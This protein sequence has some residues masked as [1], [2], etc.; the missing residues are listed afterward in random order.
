MKTPIASVIALCTALAL[1]SFAQAEDAEPDI[2]VMRG[3]RVGPGLNFAGRSAVI[4]PNGAAATAHPLATQT[5]IDILRQGGSAVDAAIAANA[6]LGLVEPVGN[7]MGG[8]L[9][10]LIWDP[11]TEQL[12]GLNA[13][14]RSPMGATLE[15]MQAIADELTE[16]EEIP[17]YGSA[18]VT[19]PGAVDGWYMMHE[20]F[21]QMDMAELFA[22]T[23]H[24]AESGAPIPELISF[25]WNISARR[26]NQ[27]YEAGILE[28]VDNANAT[29]F[30]PAPEEG[31]LFQNPDLANTLRILSEGGREAFYEG[32]IAETM[33]AYFERIGGF[34]RYDDFASHQ[35]EWVDP[36]C[37]NYRESRVCGL[38]PNTQGVATLQ[39]LQ[40]LEDFPMREYGFGSADS[41]MA[42][43]EAKRLAFEDRALGYADM[44]FFEM[45][46]EAFIDPEYGE[47]RAAEIDL[48]TANTDLRSG[49]L[50]LQMAEER[51]R[52]GD[53]TYLTVADSN[54][55]MVSL[56]QSNYR[57]MGSGPVADGLGFMFQDRGQLFSLD[58]DHPNV[59]EPGKRPFHTIIPG[60]AFHQTECKEDCSY[61]PWLS[62]GVMGG[63][64]QPQGQTQIILNLIDYDMDLQEAGDAARWRH[65]GSCQPTD[66]FM[67]DDCEASMGVVHLESG[68]PEAVAEE[69]RA[70]GL[71]VQYSDDGGYG[72]YQAIMRDFEHGTWVAAT[73][74][75]KDGAAGGY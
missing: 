6:M 13:S 62:F 10:A 42:Q 9:F 60:F 55:M 16:G 75:R 73:E 67:N 53:T 38:P 19:V 47:A 5:A 17:A 36:L 25:Y 7:G 34:L 20:R 58:P 14:G 43:I 12:Y 61:E 56:I 59:W 31:S 65:D 52:E 45:D 66:D 74:M 22:P 2:H 15:D 4:A 29:Y 50:G 49:S 57:G 28:E 71:T 1:P 30:S 44:D 48:T 68:I 18:P 64:M 26:F 63:G 21:G 70:R 40:M 46:P 24:Y 54:G 69:L 39:M 51:L 27:V 3:D 37:V 23:I 32:E 41:L 8:D 33:S 35:G 11:E 72:G